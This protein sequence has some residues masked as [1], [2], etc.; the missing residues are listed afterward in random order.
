MQEFSA[1]EH[2]ATW[3]N[4]EDNMDFTEKMFDYI[5]KNIPELKKEVEVKDKNGVAKMV[6]F[7][8]PWK[9]IDYIE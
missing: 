4:Y 8:T 1:I 9:R 2:Y 6:N 3:W 5:F 7:S